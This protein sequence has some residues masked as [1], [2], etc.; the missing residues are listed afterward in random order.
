MNSFLSK[1]ETFLL[2]LTLFVIVGWGFYTSFLLPYKNKIKALKSDI[3]FQ[4]QK[5]VQYQNALSQKDTLQKQLTLLG[6]IPPS[7]SSDEVDASLF[8]KAIET[9]HQNHDTIQISSITPLAPEKIDLYKRLSLKVEMKT[10]MESLI[11]FIDDLNTSPEKLS[12]TSLRLLPDNEA[13]EIINASLI[14]TQILSTT[15]SKGTDL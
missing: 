5:L 7:S 4:T 1:R 3:A 12:L 8:L 15:S 13:S 14:I 9:L 6:K 11:K 2:Q 10:S